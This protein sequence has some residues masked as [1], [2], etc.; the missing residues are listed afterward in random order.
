[1]DESATRVFEA[2]ALDLPDVRIPGCGGALRRLKAAGLV[3]ST[4]KPDG[5]WPVKLTRAGDVFALQ[6]LGVLS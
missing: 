5:K 1:M 4:T 3:E 6:H 2:I